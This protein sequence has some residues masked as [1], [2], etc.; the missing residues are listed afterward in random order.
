MAQALS[1]GTSVACSADTETP[2]AAIVENIV[3]CKWSLRILKLIADGRTRPSAI[4]RSCSGLSAKVM[5][6]RLRKMTRFGILERNVFG[7]K[8]PVQV[9][10]ELTPFGHRFM[11]VINAVEQLQADV[12]AGRTAPEGESIP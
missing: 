5:N 9:E 4:Q 6:E 7:D 12:D 10:Y 3:G 1:H 11:R 2:V 8:P